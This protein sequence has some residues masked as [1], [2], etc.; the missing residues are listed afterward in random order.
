MTLQM[1]PAKILANDQAEQLCHP[2]DEPVRS[3]EDGFHHPALE[4]TT[5]K[6]YHKEMYLEMT[7]VSTNCK[8][9]SELNI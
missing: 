1:R 4:M 8:R 9:L 6:L 7:I 5:R 2:V 3:I